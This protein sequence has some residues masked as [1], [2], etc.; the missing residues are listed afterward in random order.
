[1]YFV[2]NIYGLR[3]SM[4][5]SKAEARHGVM[6][7]GLPSQFG[8]SLCGQRSVKKV[9]WDSRFKRH[10]ETQVWGIDKVRIEDNRS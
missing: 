8:K 5:E 2:G 3:L 7:I 10:I 1:M 6:I 4:A 9:G